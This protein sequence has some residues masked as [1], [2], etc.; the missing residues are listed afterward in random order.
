MAS[1]ITDATPSA[2][3]VKCFCSNRNRPWIFTSFSK[4]EHAT[5]TAGITSAG[6]NNLCPRRC[7][8][9]RRSDSGSTEGLPM[10]TP[11]KPASSAIATISAPAHAGGSASPPR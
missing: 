4:V 8:L 6:M 3:K 1:A 9:A 2:A 11:P 10:R 7:A 5:V